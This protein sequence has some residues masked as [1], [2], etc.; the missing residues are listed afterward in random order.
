MLGFYRF[1][2]R[3]FKTFYCVMQCSLCVLMCSGPPR[4]SH[5]AVPVLLISSNNHFNSISRKH[6]PSLSTTS[7]SPQ[8][9]RKHAPTITHHVRFRLEI[10]LNG[11]V[12]CCACVHA[13]A[14]TCV[15]KYKE[16]LEPRC[17]RI[18][19]IDHFKIK[20]LSGHS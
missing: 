1:K 8:E 11:C 5:T 9:D 6:Q 10:H 18:G 16:K 2:W 13:C 15:E 7:A 19:N 20:Y 3:G 17:S 12:A 4:L 14:C